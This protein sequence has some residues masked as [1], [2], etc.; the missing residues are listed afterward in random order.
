[1][2]DGQKK[3]LEFLEAEFEG[4][5]IQFKFTYNSWKDITLASTPYIKA[6]GNIDKVRIKPVVLYKQHNNVKDEWIGRT[7]YSIDGLAKLIIIGIHKS[8]DSVIT[9]ITNYTLDNL[10][11][12]FTW[13]DGSPCGEPCND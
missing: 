1:M 13:E 5:Q 9:G 7:I 10:F 11:K 12:K 4:K 3:Y 8:P 6:I 2:T